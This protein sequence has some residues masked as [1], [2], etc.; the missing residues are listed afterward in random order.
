MRVYT[1]HHRRRRA[2]DQ[3]V[4]I[5]EGFCWPAFLFN[6]LW[7]LWHR[8]WL[9]ALLLLALSSASGVLLGLAGLDPVSEAAVSIG[10]AAVV[11]YIAN[12]LR[13]WT[14][15][16]RGYS[17]ETVVTGADMDTALHRFLDGMVPWE[18]GPSS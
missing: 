1:V 13:R 12:D 9:V 6:F 18:R 16:R 3:L 2:A 4:L 10:L 14:L 5:K 7:A 17:Q 11:G 8:L 15:G